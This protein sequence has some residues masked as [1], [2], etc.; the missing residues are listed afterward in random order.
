MSEIPTIDWKDR[1]SVINMTCFIIIIGGLAGLGLMAV[2]R[3]SAF[4]DPGISTYIQLVTNLVLL[5]FGV[6]TGK[7]VATLA[8]K[9]AAKKP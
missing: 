5:A 9:A 1:I 3:P 2:F 4:S 7:E 6:L 8:Y